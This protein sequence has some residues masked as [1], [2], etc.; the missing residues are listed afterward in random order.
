LNPL[1]LP[2]EFLLGYLGVVSKFRCDT[3]QNATLEFLVQNFGDIS[4]SRM[5]RALLIKDVAGISIDQLI[6]QHSLLPF[7]RAF[8]SSKSET[9]SV[10]GQ[11]T[12][13]QLAKHGT[14]IS[15]TAPQY[16]PKCVAEDIEFWGRSYWRRN[17]QI[18]GF[19]VCPKH[20][21]TKLMRSADCA[22]FREEPSYHLARANIDSSNVE[23][24][25]FQRQYLEICSAL[26]DFK[27]PIGRHALVQAAK[28]RCQ[29]LGLRRSNIGHRTSLTDFV[30]SRAPSNWLRKHF[31][32]VAAV[33]RQQRH[34]LTLS[35]KNTEASVEMSALFYSA[36]FDSADQALLELQAACRPTTQENVQNKSSSTQTSDWEMS[37]A[38]RVYSQSG[39]NTAA[40]AREFGL[41]ARTLRDV[42][43]DH[44]LPPIFKALKTPAGRALKA[45]LEGSTSIES[46]KIAG[47]Q[48]QEF[49]K[50]LR[51]AA[52]PLAKVIARKDFSSQSET[53][54][55]KARKGKQ[56]AQDVTTEM[57]RQRAGRP[58]TNQEDGQL[59]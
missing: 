37:T 9:E 17:H 54:R 21:S 57:D 28:K 10:E 16:C 51:L 50:L 59:Q 32:A 22:G 30:L 33:D 15:S 45:Y 40:V 31:P 47:N 4:S 48:K 56:E 44:G 13:G 23:P 55:F 24:S 49:E 39:G 20:H 41:N 7:F 53:P 8:A 14:R 12:S 6:A 27:Q 26:I 2:E 19:D 25:S 58:V 46:L 38:I 29:E 5:P 42:M 35:G 1:L 11:L 3:T 52:A 43:I 18:L 34:N 36:L